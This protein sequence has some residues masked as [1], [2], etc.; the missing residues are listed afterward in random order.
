M[1]CV[2]FESE[3]GETDEELFLNMNINHKA[4]V[5]RRM[6]RAFLRSTFNKN[7]KHLRINV[8]QH[9]RSCHYSFLS[10]GGSGGGG[11]GRLTPPPKFIFARQFEN[12]YGLAFSWTLPPGESLDPSLLSHCRFVVM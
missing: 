9:R 6:R 10:S 7:D 12:V 5:D 8:S 3:A 4:A 2:Q 11:L 1:L